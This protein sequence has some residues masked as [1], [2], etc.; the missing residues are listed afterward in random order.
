MLVGPAGELGTLEQLRLASARGADLRRRSATAADEPRAC[1]THRRAERTA[2]GR[3]RAAQK[4][5]RRAERRHRQL[6]ARFE[7]LRRALSQWQAEGGVRAARRRRVPA[8]RRPLGV[9]ARLVRA[10]CL[11]LHHN[12]VFL[13]FC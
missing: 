1:P 11:G 4:A 3:R 7:Q 5:A 2:F 10:G 9:G 12:F 8:R 6:R 13:V